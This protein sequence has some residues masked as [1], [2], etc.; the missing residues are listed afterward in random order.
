MDSPTSTGNAQNPAVLFINMG[1]PRNPDEVGR[2]MYNLFNDVHIVDVSQP[3][4]SLIARMISLARVG[5]VK[6]SY[7]QIGGQSPIF[8][9]TQTQAKKTVSKL[10]VKYPN[11]V[12]ADGY[13]YA[14]PFIGEAICELLKDNPEQIVVVPLYPYYSLA[15]LGSMYSDIERARLRYGLSDTLKIVPPFYEHPLYLKASVE[16]LQKALG[17]IDKDKPYRVIFSA[18]SLPASFVLKKGDPYRQQVERTIAHIQRRLDLP[19]AMLSFQSKIGP[20]KWM[21]PATIDTV[22]TT[23]QEGIKQIVVMPIGFVCD[24]IETLHELD[25][26]LAHIAK[27]AGIETF[28]RARVFNVSELFIEMLADC[29]DEALG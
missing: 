12:W 16:L 10:R 13:S 15:T 3:L 25:I 14:R 24:H 20:V 18:H 8:K 21:G 19:D 4:R 6:K 9:W 29:V 5:K 28:V 7:K 27:Q 23:G 17:R 22:E 26:E 11:I 1:G 2:F